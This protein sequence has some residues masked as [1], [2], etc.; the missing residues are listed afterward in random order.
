M[1]KKKFAQTTQTDITDLMTTIQL[2]HQK[3][4]VLTGKNK[5]SIFYLYI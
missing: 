3:V 1:Y 2:L 5:D 4:D